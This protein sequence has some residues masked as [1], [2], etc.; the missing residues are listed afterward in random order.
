MIGVPSSPA[1]LGI[2]PLAHA[3]VYHLSSYG[4]SADRYIVV[5]YNLTG[6]W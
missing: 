1:L 3:C 5:I 4:R 2:Y 6:V